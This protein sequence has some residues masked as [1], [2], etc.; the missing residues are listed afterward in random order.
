MSKKYDKKLWNEIKDE[1]RE[2]L[3]RYDDDYQTWSEVVLDC[4]SNTFEE[5]LGKI[6]ED[7]NEIFHSMIMK[8]I[9]RLGNSV[10]KNQQD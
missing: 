4:P 8:E 7:Q 1:L 5:L 3:S 6:P 2:D 9:N 10:S